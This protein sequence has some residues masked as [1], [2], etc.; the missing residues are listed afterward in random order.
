MENEDIAELI[1]PKKEHGGK[2]RSE[3]QLQILAMARVKALEVRKRN[4]ELRKLAKQEEK[5]DRKEI[6]KEIKQ[7]VT[8]TIENETP[9]DESS[10]SSES[11]D[12]EPAPP[13]PPPKIKRNKNE[14][15]KDYIKH[16]LEEADR[17]IKEK[18]V[19]EAEAPVISTK[20]KIDKKTGR[21]YYDP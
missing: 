6:K 1:E 13:P 17:Q 15:A 12:E 19:H 8:E 21:K 10:E 4:A 18:Y 2:I 20:W 14:K 16:I 9:K 11:E 5:K 3:K 7:A